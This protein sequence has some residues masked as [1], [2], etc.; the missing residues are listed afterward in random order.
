MQGNILSKTENEN[1]I[2]KNNTEKENKTIDAHSGGCRIFYVGGPNHPLGPQALK[3]KIHPSSGGLGRQGSDC[4][5]IG[6]TIR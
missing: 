3:H 6:A 4:L 2:W 1:K 5:E